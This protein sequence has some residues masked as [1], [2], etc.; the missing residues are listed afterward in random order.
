MRT[1]KL[2]VRVL[3]LTVLAVLNGRPGFITIPAIGPVSGPRVTG[4][5]GESSR[6][7][8]VELC[9]EGMEFRGLSVNAASIARL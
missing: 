9:L 6:D 7:S 5:E 8:P 1:G 3:A 4:L 2:N